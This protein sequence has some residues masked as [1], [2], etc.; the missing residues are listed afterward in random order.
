MTAYL[1]LNT[2]AGLREY[3]VE[4]IKETPKR[5]RVRLL[6][7][8]PLP[9]LVEMLLEDKPEMREQLERINKKLDQYD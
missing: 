3:P 5:Y 9:K 8:T 1:C 4:I 7:K 2:W 6:G